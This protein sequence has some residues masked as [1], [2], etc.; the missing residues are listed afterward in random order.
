MENAAA[1]VN[2]AFV[3]LVGV[4][5]LFLTGGILVW[6]GISKIWFLAEGVPM[7]IIPRF[8]YGMIPAG[9]GAIV[10]GILLKWY[11]DSETAWAVCCGVVGP[12]FIASQA[13]T[14]WRPHW[15]KPT[16]Y[17]WLEKHHG[18]IIPVLQEEG[19]K[20]GRWEWQRRVATRKGLEQWIEEVRQKRGLG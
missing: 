11:P 1:N 10:W 9:L 16:W 19:R 3:F 7:L 15:V 14:I 18:D 17:R 8:V 6:T 4:G 12:L 5:V 13:L 20:I 2:G